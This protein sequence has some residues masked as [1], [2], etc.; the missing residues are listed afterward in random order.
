VFIL[1]L[2]SCILLYVLY[3]AVNTHSAKRGQT[4]DK[5]TDNVKITKGKH[6]EKFKEHSFIN[7]KCVK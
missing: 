2:T 6:N 1:S 3:F 4:Y 5:A 7:K